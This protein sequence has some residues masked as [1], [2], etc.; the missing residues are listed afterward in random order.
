VLCVLSTTM[1]MQS[2]AAELLLLRLAH[3]SFV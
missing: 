2:L 1:V 3:S